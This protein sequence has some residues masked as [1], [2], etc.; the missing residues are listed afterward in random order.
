MLKFEPIT[1]F[2]RGLIFQLLSQSFSDVLDNA[3]KQ[4]IE[5]YDK[6]AFENPDTV[7]AYVFISSLNGAV[8]GM[9]SWDPRQWPE[10]GIIGYNCIVP[11]FHGMG[12]GQVQI[13]EVLNRFKAMGFKK[14]IVTTGNHP[15]FLKAAKMYLACGFTEIRRYNEGRDPRYGSIDYEIK[16]K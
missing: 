13:K 8:V 15:F 10:I 2:E 9:A 12:F 3:L 5:A 1:K 6:E 14:A 4:K 7:G 16:L 11:D